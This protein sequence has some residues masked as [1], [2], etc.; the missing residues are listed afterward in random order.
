MNDLLFS[1]GFEPLTCDSSELFNEF[2]VFM[3]VQES[4]I[5]E[6]ISLTP[7]RLFQEIKQLAEKRYQYMILPKKQHQLTC[8]ESQNNKMSLLRDICLSI[9]LTLNFS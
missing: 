2:D 3:N 6:S 8:L 1:G 9:G 7:K 4:P 5:P